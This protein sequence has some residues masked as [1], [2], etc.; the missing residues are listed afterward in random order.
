[1]IN[2]VDLSWLGLD[3]VL[4]VAWSLGVQLVVFFYSGIT[5]VL[6]H[7]LGFSECH[8]TFLSSPH[9]WLIIDHIRDSFV[10]YVDSLM[11]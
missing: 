8:K 3:L 11:G 2:L 7:S 10:P 5:V 4:P 9:L 6:F 1:M